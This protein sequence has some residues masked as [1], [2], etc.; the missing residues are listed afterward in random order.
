MNFDTIEYLKDGNERQQKAYLVLKQNKILTALTKFDPILV[1]TI[2]IN[3]DIDDSDLD[4]ICCWQNKKDFSSTVS[5]LFSSEA[6]FILKESVINDAESIISNFKLQNF[7]IE[8]FGQNIPTRQQ[9][10]YRHMIIEHK[11]LVAKG[12]NFRQQVIALKKQGYKTEPAF[13]QLLGLKGNPYE[14]LLRYEQ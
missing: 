5:D 4:I 3:I 10:G 12:E 11:L 2:P 1:G 6:G 8:I 14:E 13:A 7:R 9:F